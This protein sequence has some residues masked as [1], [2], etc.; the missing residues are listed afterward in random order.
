MGDMN[1]TTDHFHVTEQ[2]ITKNNT[3][4]IQESNQVVG[5]YKDEVLCDVVPMH[6]G[7]VLFGWPWQYDRKVTFDGLINK[8][9][10]TLCG[11]KFAFYF[12]CLH[13]KYI[14]TNWN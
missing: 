5:R 11:K 12:R 9:T 8:Y 6:A 10:F 1:P 7:D 13:M 4:K 2:A 14:V 3:K